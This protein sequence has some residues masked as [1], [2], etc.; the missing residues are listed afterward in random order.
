[1]NTRGLLAYEK[2]SISVS[3]RARYGPYKPRYGRRSAAKAKTRHCDDGFK[4]RNGDKEAL[5][6]RADYLVAVAS[7][8]LHNSADDR[9]DFD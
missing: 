5:C 9:N 2:G 7:R 8:D 1:M 6:G 4:L 3:Q